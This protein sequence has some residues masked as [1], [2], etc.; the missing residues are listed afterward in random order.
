MKPIESSGG[1]NNENTTTCTGMINTIISAEIPAIL[2]S[3]FQLKSVF[4][5]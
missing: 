2:Y 3:F 1:G 4:I 5:A